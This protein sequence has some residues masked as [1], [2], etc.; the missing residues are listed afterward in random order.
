MHAKE[1]SQVVW[2]LFSSISFSCSASM[3]SAR[4][5]SMPAVRSTVRYSTAPSGGAAAHAENFVRCR[6]LLHSG[7]AGTTGRAQTMTSAYR[8]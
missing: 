7:S 2:H 4:R 6:H 1:Q 3:I 5:M 8:T